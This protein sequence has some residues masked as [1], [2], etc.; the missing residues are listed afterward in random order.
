MRSDGDR[1]LASI[2][3]LAASDA[4]PSLESIGSRLRSFA[5]WLDDQ[6]TYV[7]RFESLV[8]PRGDGTRENQLRE[9]AGLARHVGRELS[10][11]RARAIA[12][13]V[14]SPRSATFHRGRIGD[15]RNHFDEAHVGAFKEI[16][17]RELVRLGYERDL[18]W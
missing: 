13:H 18:N 11:G 14:W 17:G 2:T 12:D 3:G 10:E 4:G 1:L 9:I 8:G 16:A 7:C 6:R 5:G 15:W